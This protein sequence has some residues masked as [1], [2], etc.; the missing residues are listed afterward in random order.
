VRDHRFAENSAW[1]QHNQATAE[2]LAEARANARAVAEGP[3]Q[4][5]LL[6]DALKAQKTN[7]AGIWHAFTDEF[8]AAVVMLPQRRGEW[9]DALKEPFLA[10]EVRLPQGLLDTREARELAAASR[11][12]QQTKAPYSVWS[13][14][15]H[16]VSLYDAE[17]WSL[18]PLLIRMHP[19]DGLSALDVLPYPALMKEVLRRTCREDR[20]LIEA[21]VLSAPLVFDTEGA[22]A[23]GRSVAALL[24]VEA[25]TEHAR[26][27]HEAMS[28][29]ARMLADQDRKQAATQALQDL[30]EKEL[31]AWLKH[32]FG[33]VLQRPDGQQIAL[34][35]L[36]HLCRE[37]LLGRGRAHDGQQ[38][39]QAGIA[40]LA[41]LVAALRGTSIGVAQMRALWQRAVK[42]SADQAAES[43]TRNVVRRRSARDEKIEREG[44]GARTL[45]GE[46]L[47]L[48]YGAALLQGDA[49]GSATEISAFFDWFEELLVGRD[50]GLSLVNH[51]DSFTDVPQRFG[52]LLSRLPDPDARLRAAYEKLEPQRRRALFSSRYDESYPD[53]E[54]VILLRVGLNAAANWLDRDREQ[55]SA[56]RALFAW[57]YAQA[58][59]LWLTAVLDTGDT[60]QQLVAACFAFM[61]FVFGELLGEA[62]KETIPP[63]ANDAGMLADACVNLQVNRVEAL[64]LC[65]LV[66][67]AG[68][69]LPG[70]LRDLQQWSDLTGREEDF[71]KH[72]A[73]LTAALGNLGAVPGDE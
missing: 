67:E 49:S 19:V 38:T 30:E 65:R 72:W 5:K 36:E 20:G 39:W 10:A 3:V 66:A 46:G 68:A 1:E 63:I 16:H 69:D 25:I 13:G 11:E 4:V 22:W 44:E 23:P 62:L 40:A 55:V 6:V 28:Y 24:V 2:E 17:V 27:L 71:P 60:K 58:R 43:A 31:P 41:G 47:P 73:K 21:L 42:L 8:V 45:H 35:Y 18:G 26:K 12:W 57:I 64:R 37:K 14:R 56:A 7:R 9:S 29:T 54:S 34:A 59:R 53:L 70:A 15:E 50:P 51:G 52:F 48:F 32:A 61:P 33:L